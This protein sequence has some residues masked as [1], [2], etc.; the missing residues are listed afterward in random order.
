MLP[1]FIIEKK[2]MDTMF[3]FFSFKF[4]DEIQDRVSKSIL[5]SE[6][7]S[8]RASS[9]TEMFSG[10]KK[11][12]ESTRKL[13]LTTPHFILHSLVSWESLTV[14]QISHC[15]VLYL[16]VKVQKT[17]NKVTYKDSHA[18]PVTP[19][20]YRFGVLVLVNRIWHPRILAQQKLIILPILVKA[21]G[22]W[23]ILH[24]C[25]FSISI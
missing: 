7:I 17:L 12:T 22:Y 15:L 14:H 3:F 24:L 1:I 4:V 5:K 10:K 18:N 20:F 2:H 6:V 25:H 21:K 23:D 9:V 11:L 19:V 13:Q 8:V 16:L